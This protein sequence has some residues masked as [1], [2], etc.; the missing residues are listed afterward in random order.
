MQRRTRY[1]GYPDP[2]SNACIRISGTYP[3]LLSQLPSR[4]THHSNKPG[5]CVPTITVWKYTSHG[6]CLVQLKICLLQ[7]FPERNWISPFFTAFNWP[8]LTIS[9]IF[10]NHC[11][12][13]IGSTVVPQRSCVPTLWECGTTFTK[14]PAS[15]KSSTNGFSCTRSGPFPHI[16]LLTC[17]WLHRH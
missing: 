1:P 16:F 17:S 11:C 15:S 6:Y 10:T 7:T 13:I 5:F 3:V 8:V 12:L 14:S 2:V 4:R 9:S